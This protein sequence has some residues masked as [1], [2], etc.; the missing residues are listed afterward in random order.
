MMVCMVNMGGC[1][2]WR[3]GA[4]SVCGVHC[5][6]VSNMPICQPPAS[7]EEGEQAEEK[8]TGDGQMRRGRLAERE[9]AGIKRE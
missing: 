6:I 8:A 9:G 2:L 5:F 4:H 1:G 3:R 7:R